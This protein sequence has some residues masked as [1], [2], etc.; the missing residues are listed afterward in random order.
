MTLASLSQTRDSN[1]NND[2]LP[3]QGKRIDRALRHSL[4]E[5]GES[6][7]TGIIFD[8]EGQGI[9]LSDEASYYSLKDV[10]SKL[11]VIFGEDGT[12]L[13]MERIREYL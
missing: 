4:K 8:L 1:G 7:L 11:R 12:A 2:D 3:V 9:R 10:E 13:L 5:L 6:A